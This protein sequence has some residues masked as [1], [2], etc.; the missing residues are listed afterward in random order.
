MAWGGWLFYQQQMEALKPPPAPIVNSLDRLPTLT[1]GPAPTSTPERQPV[2]ASSETVTA[3]GRDDGL[4]ANPELRLAEAPSATN[5]KPAA[6]ES[7]T[8]PLV[9]TTLASPPEGIPAPITRLVAGRIALN[10]PVVEVGWREWTE[11]GQVMRLWEVA[12]YAAGWH[13]NSALP[14][15]PGNIVL[16]GHHNIKGEVFRYIADLEIGD[17][18]TLYMGEQPYDY[19]VEDKFIVKDLDEPEEVRIANARWIGPFEDERLTLVT[20]WPYTGN[21]HRVIVIAKPVGAQTPAEQPAALDSFVPADATVDE[22]EK[23]GVPSE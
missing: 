14:G 1:P 22:T 18:I 16:S 8:A 19:K 12:N 5:H 3:P 21:S 10:A 17:V 6:K 7:V 4:V 20:C 23:L 11:N 2:A 9:D 13:K 15:Q